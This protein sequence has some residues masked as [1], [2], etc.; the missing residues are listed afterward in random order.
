LLKYKPV[1]KTI[2]LITL[3]FSSQKESISQPISYSS[4]DIIQ[5]LNKL[6]VLGSVLYVAAHPD[7]ENTAVLTYMSKGKL[8]RTAYLSLTR[9]D[10]GQNLLGNENGDLLGVIRTQE[11]LSA[12]KIDGA[13]Q[14]F[15]RAIDFGYSKT[16]K[17]T[18][19][20][21]DKELLLKDIV[22]V[23][24]EFKPDVIITRFSK[25]QG[26]HGHHLTSAILAEEAFYAA[27][28]PNKFP[29]QLDNLEPW[30]AKRLYWNT[31]QPSDKAVTI[32]IGEYNSIIG[33]SYNELA[34]YARSMHK[35]QGFGVSPNRGTQLVHFD[36]IAGDSAKIDL[37]EGV[38][39]TWN[40]VIG[41]NII[42]VDI[43]NIIEKFEPD[44]PEKIIPM[45]LNLYSKIAKIDNVH[46]RNI[47]SNEIKEL[48]KMCSG[49]W[50]ESILPKAELVAGE[51]V[52]LESTIINRSNY[53]IKLVDVK[54]NFQNNA[55]SMNEML[56]YNKPI[57]IEQIINIDDNYNYTQPFW[58]ADEHDGNHFTITNINKVTDAD[59]KPEIIST[60]T[61]NI[62]RINLS[63]EI[64]TYYKWTD[65]VK[66]E[67]KRPV[68]IIPKLSLSVDKENYI[69]VNGK[70]HQIKVTLETKVD[71][72]EGKLFVDLP[73][74]WNVD[75]DNYNFDLSE[76]GDRKEFIFT[77]SPE[78]NARTLEV[79]FWAV[80]DGK[81]FNDEIV[82]ID[83][84][85]IKHQT[86]LKPVKADL[87]KLDI[88]IE[89]KRIGYIMGSGD[90]IPS[91]L[92]QL[93]Y[94]IDHLSDEDL[95]R[96]DLKEYDVII[97]GIRAFNTRPELERQQKRLI[98]FVENG[99]TWIVQ[100]NTRF[101]INVDQIGPFPFSTKGRDRISEEDAKL[102]ILVPEHPI[103]NYPNKITEKDFDNWVQERGLYFAES[104]EGKLYPLLAGSDE[105]ETSKLGGLLIAE[106]GKGVFIFTAYSWFR[107]LPAGVPGAYRLFV[108]M[109]SAKG[110]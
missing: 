104:W 3:L 77:I 20:N 69:F 37:F 74:G 39:I 2:I 90:D 109:I 14:F 98:E 88:K 50:M 6:K 89:P 47:K 25:T 26:G 33:K 87:V 75:I 105:G 97:C 106:Y 94:E 1:L 78:Q 15:T 71:S 23:I 32:D 58:L 81:T 82:Q 31:W 76:K 17:E 34:A 21:W 103:F 42:E 86:V 65:A 48:I 102:E 110:K 67:L 96:K 99:G 108:N 66:G 59:N 80:I 68:V 91:S 36:Y 44:N 60:F 61:I 41:G 57:T 40:K 13:E 30:Q 43:N 7:D 22:K 53:P 9:G 63:Y 49:L 73:Q 27:A 46:W 56:F 19:R 107:Q 93:G 12:R 101:G 84:P 62:D 10:G 29:E 95:E 11:L 100:H 38:D 35:S 54:T 55:E 28:D 4:S 70:K 79:K 45:L 8:T 5:S 16:A 51:N 52:P 85:H 83:Y 92:S 64:P 18:L 72:A 24:R